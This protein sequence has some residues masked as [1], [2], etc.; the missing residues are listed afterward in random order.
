MG[1]SVAEGERPDTTQSVVEKLRTKKRRSAAAPRRQVLLG[2]RGPRGPRRSNALGAMGRAAGQNGGTA[3]DTPDLGW[4]SDPSRGAPVKNSSEL[5]V[6]G[7][8]DQKVAEGGDALGL[9]QGVGIDQMHV[10]AR[11]R[12]VGQHANQMRA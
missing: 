11:P 12:H 5:P 9:A 4:K 2:M 7:R 10:E 6:F 3:S 1:I 8:L